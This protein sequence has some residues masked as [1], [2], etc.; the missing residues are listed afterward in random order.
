[1]KVLKRSL[2]TGGTWTTSTMELQGDRRD[3]VYYWLQDEGFKPVLA[4]G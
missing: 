2:G 3:D 1:L 4:G